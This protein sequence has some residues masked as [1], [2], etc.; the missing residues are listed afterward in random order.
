MYDNP[1]MVI[2]PIGEVLAIVVYRS[3]TLIR[4]GHDF[5]VTCLFVILLTISSS[6]WTSY[7]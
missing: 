3:A 2:I 7:I 1:K 5:T 4:H 6:R